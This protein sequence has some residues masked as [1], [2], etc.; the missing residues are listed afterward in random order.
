M[1]SLNRSKFVTEV[2]YSNSAM[3][4][5][6]FLSSVDYDILQK[7]VKRFILV[8][9]DEFFDTNSMDQIM[10]TWDYFQHN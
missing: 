6:E 1:G 4:T 3:R 10:E 9:G 7:D 5:E 8:Q 2:L